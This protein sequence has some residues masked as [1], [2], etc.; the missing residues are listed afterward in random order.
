MNRPGWAQYYMGIA[1]AVAERSNCL[2]RKV[3]ALVVVDKSIIST[4]YNGSPMGVTNCCDG[5]CPRCAS[6]APSGT[7]L[8]EC[9]CSHAEENAITQAAY[10]GTSIQGAVLYCTISPCLICTKMI[11]NSGIREVV[12][13]EA[14]HFNEQTMTLLNQAGVECRQFKRS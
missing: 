8:G 12:Y 1:E 10:H 7:E 3:G 14:Y 4:G 2:R 9:I 5:G 13:E 6:D 11:I